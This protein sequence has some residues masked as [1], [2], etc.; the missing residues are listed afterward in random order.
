MQITPQVS[1]TTDHTLPFL[2]ASRQ[3]FM[4]VGAVSPSLG[5]MGKG[6]DALLQ[7]QGLQF[8]FKSL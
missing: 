4:D 1:H 7:C 5:G 8:L 3:G 2:S 6:L